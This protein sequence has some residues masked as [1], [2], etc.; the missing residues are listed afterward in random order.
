[1]YRLPIYLKLIKN[2]LAG[3]FLTYYITHGIYDF[4][5]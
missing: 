4:Y 3:D 5:I 2:T 1:M